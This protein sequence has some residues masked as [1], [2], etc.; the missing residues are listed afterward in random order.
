M[1]KLDQIKKEAYDLEKNQNGHNID[2]DM[3]KVIE[4]LRIH[5]VE[6]EIQNEELIKSR[7]Q[8][9][10]THQYLSDI[11]YHAPVGYLILSEEGHIIDING[12]ALE[13]FGYSQ[14][15][16]INQRFQSYIP[17]DSFVSFK[18]CMS[19]LKSTAS[20]QTAEIILKRKNNCYFW[21]KMSFKMVNHPDKGQQ[22]LCTLLDITR[23]KQIEMNLIHTNRKYN[24]AVEQSPLSIMI[25]DISGRIEYVNK[26]FTSIT[27][28]SAKEVIGKNPNFLSSGNQT[29]SFYKNMWDRL[30]AGKEWYGELCN[31]KKSGDIYWEQASI[32]PV[33]NE[34][35]VIANFVAVKEDITLKKIME[36]SLKNQNKFLQDLIN[37][38]P[39]PVFYTDI[40]GTVIGYNQCFAN[41]S[42]LDDIQIKRS[43]I[44]EILFTDS[45]KHTNLVKRYQEQ[46]AIIMSQ[47]IIF[48][49][50]DGTNR[51]I[52]LKL[53]SSNHA[54]KELSGLIGA[55]L[56]ITEHRSLQQDLVNTI[57][58]VNILAQ[59]A[60][61]ASKAKSQFLAN[62]SHEIRTPM[63]AIMGMLD[64]L[65]SFTELD[66]EQKEYIQTAKESAQNLLTVIDDI[67]DFSKIEAQKL[68]LIETAF[69]MHQL[70]HSFRKAMNIHAKAKE[71]RLELDIH[72]DVP[73]HVKGDPDRIRQIL[74]NIVG[75]AI[76]FTDQGQV[77]MHVSLL[78]NDN[79]DNNILISFR[80]VDSGVGIP[81]A[82][83]EK[84]FDSF[85]QSDGSL[86]RKYEGTGLGLAI[87][88][89]LCELMGGT[90]SVKSKPGVGSEFTFTI[91][92]LSATSSKVEGEQP[93]NA[94]PKATSDSNKISK[95][96]LV[97]DIETNRMVGTLYLNNLG[98][99]VT[100]ANNG[101]AAIE[102]MKKD[103]FDVVFLDIEMPGLN[104]FETTQKIRDGLAGEQNKNIYIIALTAHALSG[105]R[106]K[107]LNASMNDYISKPVSKEKLQQVLYQI[108]KR[109]N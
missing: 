73:Q 69:D 23:E 51:N 87:S 15:I 9:E 25:T 65:F 88:K 53:A 107:C 6:L 8:L 26:R 105:Y 16:M 109:L 93:K 57:E 41:Y 59:K 56:D 52:M 94:H 14:K 43:K 89:Q 101:E 98:Y 7:D 106:E 49:H 48:Q 2:T 84:I 11:F 1:K 33:K 102:K 22:I 40:Y 74:T 76:K 104:G 103:M 27:G 61:I 100:V 78:E 79:R 72:P 12:V 54:Q 13:Y 97:E 81:E 64:I 71:L 24:I 50:S 28:Y 85:S 91:Q 75:N 82:D 31:K 42:G 5:Q 10:K 77:S 83:F 90:V 58:K 47:E 44:S 55:M 17:A 37:T 35:G 96:L 39:L 29:S 18:E 21:A 108:P 63:N 95:V 80:I 30:L 45:E 70:L 19:L 67:L 34:E 4:N 20:E 46:E 3:Q 86:T 62:M 92:L 99:S 38:I 68:T 66:G 60:E 36:N 32:S